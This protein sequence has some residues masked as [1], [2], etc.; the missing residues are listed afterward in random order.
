MSRLCWVAI[1]LTSL[2]LGCGGGATAPSS[3]QPQAATSPAQLKEMLE[4]IAKTGESGSAT[5]GLRP[6]IEAFAKENPDKG[7]ALLKDLTKLEA[8]RSPEEVKTIAQKMAE[9]L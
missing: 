3:S 2:L 5:M 7:G 6:G 8:A 1:C 4:G 9:Q